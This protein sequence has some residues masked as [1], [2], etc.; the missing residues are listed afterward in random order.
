M[1]EMDGFDVTRHIREDY[2]SK[3][4]VI[5]MLTS[6]NSSSDMQICKEL[7]INAYLVKPVR[8]RELID[9]ILSV[10]SGDV[11]FREAPVSVSSLPKTGDQT[12]ILLV[13]DSPDNILLVQTYLSKGGFNVD[14][15]E[16]GEIAVA[17]YKAK[18]YDLV[19]MDMEMPI[20]DG[21]TAT[22][23]I[24]EWEKD[25]GRRPVPIIALTAY[26]FEE[27][28]QKCLA[29]GCT[30]Y[31]TKPVRKQKL[32]QVLAQYLE[33]EENGKNSCKS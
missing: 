24:R 4:V 12:R 25:N 31:V 8:R 27:D 32:L 15:A 16:N 33:G 17:K 5:M 9:T 19:L 28:R 3:D 6:D 21:Y 20:M 7:R 23:L 14:I 29:A 10:L 11:V 1:P 22:G 13:E 26:A 18:E 30:D 2:K